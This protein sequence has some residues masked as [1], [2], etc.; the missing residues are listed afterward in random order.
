MEPEA[1]PAAEFLMTSA[2]MRLK[3]VMT[4]GRSILDKSENKIDGDTRT[5]HTTLLCNPI[6]CRR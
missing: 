1:D 5:G 6:F 3:K 4:P 2:E